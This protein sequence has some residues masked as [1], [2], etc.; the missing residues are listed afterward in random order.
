MGTTTNAVD[1][2]IM[3]G[4]GWANLGSTPFR[5][6]KHYTNEGGIRSPAIVQW[7]AGLG[8]SL[9]GKVTHQVGDVR[10]IMPTVLE[11]AGV[12][13]PT[14]WTDVA[15]D[16][17]KVLAEQGQSLLG[18]LK[19]G[20]TFT[21][22]EL[23]WEH[24][25]NRAYRIGDWKIVSQN[26][27]ATDGMPA[28]AWELY[29]LASDPNELNDVAGDPAQA[30]RL[31]LMTE[32]YD[33]WAYQTNVTATFPWSA[34]DLNRD[35]Q[36]NSADLQTFIAG[37]LKADPV[38]NATTFARGDINLDGLTDLSDFALLRK[39]FSMVGHGSMLDGIAAQLP[40]PSSL[41]QVAL[42][43]GFCMSWWGMHARQQEMRRRLVL[44]RLATK[45]A[46][47]E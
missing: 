11:A 41:A 42:I 21:H 5:N 13:Y 8:S 7:N 10:D 20:D 27:A 3:Y 26:F 17:Y 37:W 38:G 19:T 40:E 6:Q 14:Q 25:G 35:G 24:E 46:R 39:A 43:I 33:R 15:G 32:A 22:N 29:N 2:G 4:T 1:N 9:L 47:L 16:S 44:Q 31:A 18:L 23:G 45:S 34:A 30:N 12:N 36:L 28:N